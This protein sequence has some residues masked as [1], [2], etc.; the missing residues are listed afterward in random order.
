MSLEF[1]LEEEGVLGA[2]YRGEDERLELLC[3]IP[4]FAIVVDTHNSQS[5]ERESILL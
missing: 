1:C 3:S 2:V 5:A 4:Y